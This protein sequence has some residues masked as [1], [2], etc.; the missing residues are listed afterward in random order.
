MLNDKE[1]DLWADGYDKSVRLCEEAGEYPF[2]GYKDVLNEIYRAVHR[3]KN[4]RVLDIGFGTGV[5]TKKLYDD[6]YEIYGIDFSE[7]MIAIAKEK[8]PDAVLIQHDFSNGLPKEIAAKRFDFIIST[9]AMHHLTDSGKAELITQLFKCLSAD[10]RI[11]IGDVAFE[12]REELNVCKKE[13]G[14]SWDSDEIY[15]VFNELKQC[16]PADKI[17]YHKKSRCAGIVTCMK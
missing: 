4:A 14:D 13:S 12:T 9:Y 3:K 8:M 5:L 11:F 6:G 16:F 1:F 15:I 10:G 2:A 7:R 17:Q